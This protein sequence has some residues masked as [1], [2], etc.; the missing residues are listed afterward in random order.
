MFE[1]TI[2]RFSDDKGEGLIASCVCNGKKFTKS[3]ILTPDK[4]KN[5]LLK[6]AIVSACNSRICMEEC[7]RRKIGNTK[8]TW[9]EIK[10]N[11][12]INEDSVL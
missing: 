5:K 7:K 1:I 8:E 4:E 10:K 11:I 3:I 6:G 9:D 12:K 2:K